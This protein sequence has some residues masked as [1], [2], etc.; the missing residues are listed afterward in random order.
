MFQEVG[1]EPTS[2]PQ[3]SI[4]NYQQKKKI[5]T[6]WR[7]PGISPIGEPIPIPDDILAE[8]ELAQD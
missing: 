7:Y 6:A 8:I 3:F 1:K 2:N 5:I 4:I